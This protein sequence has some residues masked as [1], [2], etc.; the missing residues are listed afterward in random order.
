MFEILCSRALILNLIVYTCVYQKRLIICAVE[1]LHID[2]HISYELSVHKNY[3]GMGFK[4]L[5]SFNAAMLGKQAWQFQTEVGSL[6]SRLFKAR[7][8]PRSDYLRAS[9]GANPSYIW[10]SIHS[11]QRLIRQGA[12]WCIGTGSSIPLMN[13]PWLVNGGCITSLNTGGAQFRT[14]SISDLIDP[15]TKAWR[16]D[17]ISHLFDD[18]TTDAILR[19]LLFPQV[20]S[21]AL[22]WSCERNGQYSVRSAYRIYTEFIKVAAH[23]YRPGPWSSIWKMKVPPKVKNLVWRVCRGC[24]PTRARLVIRGLA[25]PVHC[26]LCNDGEEDS[27][28][29]LFMCS[30]A[31]QVWQAAHLWGFVHQAVVECASLDGILFQLIQKVPA[32]QCSLLAMLFMESMETP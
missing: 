3:G 25:C 15:S 14:G 13:H 2:K 29:T 27:I 12:R 32:S 11:V 6:V 17:L 22:S 26:V 16:Q 28:H 10:R 5:A 4:D 24:L 18:S 23:L 8:F 21:D 1:I 31:R 7:Y 20:L 30:R 19:T 9:I